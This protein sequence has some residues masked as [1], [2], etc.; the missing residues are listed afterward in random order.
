[1]KSL[2]PCNQSGS[3][4]T[5]VTKQGGWQVM[6]RLFGYS[7]GQMFVLYLAAVPALLG[8]IALSTDV[9]IMYFNWAS[10][11][12]AVDGAALAGSNYLP[13]D[14]STAAAQATLVA[15]LNGLASSEAATTI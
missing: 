5:V 11:Q 12:R 8:A 2:R 1:M 10:M 3:K 6:K 15:A 9:G 14:T 7:K 13:E 4:L